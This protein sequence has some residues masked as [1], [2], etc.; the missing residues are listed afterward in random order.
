MPCGKKSTDKEASTK[1][2]EVAAKTEAAKP[3]K[4]CGCRKK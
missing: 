3:A 2:T 4:R 1:K